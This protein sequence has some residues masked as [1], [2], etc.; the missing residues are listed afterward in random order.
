MALAQL[1]LA[2]LHDVGQGKIAAAFDKHIQR[3][4]LDCMDRPADPKPRTITLQIEITPRIEPGGDCT[5]V[6]VQM[7]ATSKVPTHK[8][9][10]INMAVRRGGMLVF[11]PDS[12]H[13]VD[14]QS[15]PIDNDD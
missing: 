13:D 2:N 10:P 4:V 1:N 3:A 9:A 7:Q 5:D 11:N 6:D 8:T 12:P 14:Q 15:L